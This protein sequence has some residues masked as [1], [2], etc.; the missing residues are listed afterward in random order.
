ML[1]N[2]S[3]FLQYDRETMYSWQELH[4]WLSKGLTGSD[5]TLHLIRH[6]QTVA[7][8][9]SLM[10]GRSEWE[11]D[12]E[13]YLQARLLGKI[14][15]GCYDFC[16][17][18]Q[19]QRTLTTVQV[20][21]SAYYEQ[22]NRLPFPWP[23]CIDSRLDERSLG[24]WE[25]MPTQ[26][27]AA[28]SQGDLTYAT[29]GGETYLQLTQ[30]VLSFLVDLRRNIQ[31]PARIL[32]S[33]HMGTL[34]ILDGILSGKV[35]SKEILSLRFDNATPYSYSFKSLTWPEFLH[36]FITLSKNEGYVR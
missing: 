11:L 28:Y 23:V 13:G 5:L 9:Q 33:T 8:A 17:V 2:S 4:N 3:I 10:A 30:R 12:D 25:G 29:P 6:A 15:P 32:I 24:E 18:S 34:R 7:N 1:E 19:L 22:H 16:Y 26:K 20:A 14:L 35:S 21:S 36:P 27:I 31:T